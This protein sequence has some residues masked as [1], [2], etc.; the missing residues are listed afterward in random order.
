MQ[1]NLADIKVG[2]KEAARLLTELGICR[3]FG[4]R[5]NINGPNCQR[6]GHREPSTG[7]W[8]WSLKE[9]IAVARIRQTVSE[10]VIAK[11][12]GRYASQAPPTLPTA[13]LEIPSG[14][15]TED[16]WKGTYILG[17]AKGRTMF[18]T[19][20]GSSGA[21]KRANSEL[22]LVRLILAV[23]TLTGRGI[24]A[25]AYFAVLR[26]DAGRST[27]RTL[28]KWLDKYEAT[29]TVTVIERQLN[30]EESRKLEEEKAMNAA[31]QA[32]RGGNAS[33]EFSQGLAER[34]LHDQVQKLHPGAV[35][36]P[37]NNRPFG[38]AWDAWYEVPVPQSGSNNE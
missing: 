10:E 32:G 35:P 30:A 3:A 8:W 2:L 27:R 7:H 5:G 9:L 4:P 33:A 20:A 21:G 25:R 22:D 23:R 37:I 14:L 1:S 13:S 36:A 26:D 11:V 29:D 16:N 24:D 34:F 38:V 15:P 31:S 6:F 17:M 28:E 18:S 12:A 19:G